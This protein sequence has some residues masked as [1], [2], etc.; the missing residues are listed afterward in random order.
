MHFIKSFFVYQKRIKVLKDL[1]I[2]K[3]YITIIHNLE[4]IYCIIWARWGNI[5]ICQ[6]NSKQE[7]LIFKKLFINELIRYFSNI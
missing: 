6:Y 2:S 3:Q 7:S 1:V 5:E 4:H